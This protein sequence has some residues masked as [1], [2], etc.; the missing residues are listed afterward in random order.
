MRISDWSSDVCSS[1]LASVTRG[2]TFGKIG[3]L[4][5]VEPIGRALWLEAK[6][7]RGIAAEDCGL[8]GS[9]SSAEWVKVMFLLHLFGNLEPPQS[10][11]LPLRLAG[12]DGVRAPDH[13]LW[14][15]TFD[16]NAQHRGGHAR[17][18]DDRVSAVLADVG[19]NI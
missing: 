10:L 14:L 1:D 12:P 16:E 3:R 9:V 18:L 7:A 8:D 5:T 13:S 11:D 19:P 6:Q 4:V 17:L 15:Q 2:W